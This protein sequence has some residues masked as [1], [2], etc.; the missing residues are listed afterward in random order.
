MDQAHFGENRRFR[1]REASQ[2]LKDRWGLD[3]KPNTLA[4]LACIGGGPTIEYAGKFPTHTERD[5]D[6]WAKAKISPPVANTSE[7]R[8]QLASTAQ[9]A[10]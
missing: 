6:K 4:K 1:R 9:V 2:Y 10:A 7:R 5:L 8:Q 3:Y